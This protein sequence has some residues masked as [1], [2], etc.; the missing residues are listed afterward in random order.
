MAGTREKE[1]RHRRDDGFL[2]RWRGV[3]S[4]RVDVAGRPSGAVP[5]FGALGFQLT[6]IGRRT[7]RRIARRIVKSSRIASGNQRG[8]VVAEG[9]PPPHPPPPPPTPPRSRGSRRAA[10]GLRFFGG[11]LATKRTGLSASTLACSK[12]KGGGK[13]GSRG[14]PAISIRSMT[15]AFEQHGSTTS[16]PFQQTWANHRVLV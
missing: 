14:R 8:A 16:M 12:R 9:D 5:E 2:A 4:A 3:A 6:S 10:R 13:E 7:A 1:T 11:H 15:S